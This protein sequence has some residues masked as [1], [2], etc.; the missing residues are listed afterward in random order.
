MQTKIE[1]AKGLEISRV[2]T[3]LWQIADMEREGNTLDPI[4]TAKYMTPYCGSRPKLL[5]YGRPLWL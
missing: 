4:A 5:R 3:G 1:L 2:V